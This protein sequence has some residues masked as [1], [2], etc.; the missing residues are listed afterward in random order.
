VIAAKL[1]GGKGEGLA[2][3]RAVRGGKQVQHGRAGIHAGEVVGLKAGG[4]RAGSGAA[5]REDYRSLKHITPAFL[6]NKVLSANE[7]RAGAC[8]QRRC[9]ELAHCWR[10]AGRAEAGWQLRA[11]RSLRLSVLLNSSKPVKCV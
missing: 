1:H 8:K 11:S 3:A 7:V 10:M 5:A 6:A 9:E 4:G 2:L